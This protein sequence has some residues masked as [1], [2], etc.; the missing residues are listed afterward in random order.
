MAHCAR[1]GQEYAPQIQVDDLIDVER[2]LGYRYDMPGSSAGHYQ[3][4]C[5]PC[6][7]SMLAIAQGRLWADSRQRGLVAGGMPMDMA[8]MMD[9]PREGAA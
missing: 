2:R 4:V 1:C 8:A 5:P 7:R 3:R 6:R 9:A